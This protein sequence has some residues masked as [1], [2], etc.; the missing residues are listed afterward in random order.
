MNKYFMV[1]FASVLLSCFSQVLLKKSSGEKK[2]SVIFEYLNV[3][4][5]SSYGI[6]FACM[7]LMVYVYSGVEYKYGAI[8]ESL[9][10]LIIMVFSGIFLKEKITKKKI[11]GNLIIVLGV[12]IFSLNL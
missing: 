3:K 1:A 12:V 2:K 5:I 8:I 7:L 11:I 4:V 10:Y 9:A 6:L